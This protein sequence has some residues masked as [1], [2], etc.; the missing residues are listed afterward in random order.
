[1]ITEEFPTIKHAGLVKSA[2]VCYTQCMSPREQAK[3]SAADAIKILTSFGYAENAN[4]I[5]SK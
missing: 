5:V 4:I 2:P 3:R 1:M